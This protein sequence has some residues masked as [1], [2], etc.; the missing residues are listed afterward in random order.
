[1]T[2]DKAVEVILKHAKERV[3]IYRQ[4]AGL[5]VDLAEAVVVVEKFFKKNK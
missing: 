4:F 1:M 2:L 3:K 5:N